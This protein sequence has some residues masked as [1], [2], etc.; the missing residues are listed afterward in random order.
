MHWKNTFLSSG[1]KNVHDYHNYLRHL[2]APIS[3]V[4]HPGVPQQCDLQ[5]KLCSAHVPGVLLVSNGECNGQPAYLLLDE[6]KVS[7]ELLS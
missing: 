5:V 4:L 2:L 3:W 1:R 6:Y 7:R